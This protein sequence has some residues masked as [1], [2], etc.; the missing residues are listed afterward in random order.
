MIGQKRGIRL[1]MATNKGVTLYDLFR[2]EPIEMTLMI[3]VPLVLA[4]MQLVNSTFNDLSFGVSVPFAIVIVG[5]TWVLTQ[6]SF[7]RFQ[8]RQI[9]RP[10]WE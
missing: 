2:A 8:R 4:L 7:A 3:V 9:E 10:F 6:Y 1:R 5:Y